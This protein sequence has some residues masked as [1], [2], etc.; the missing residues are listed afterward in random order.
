M[1]VSNHATRTTSA[2][3]A[4]LNRLGLAAPPP[5]V[6]RLTELNALEEAVV[7]SVLLVVSGNVGSGK[8]RLVTEL[9]TRESIQALKPVFVSCR[10]ADRGDAIRARAERELGIL[11]GTLDAALRRQPRLL[12][13]DDAHHLSDSPD[14]LRGLA[15]EAGAGRVLLIASER[16]P[17]RRAQSQRFEMVLEGLDEGS[18]RELWG[19]LEERFGEVLPEACDQALIITGGLPMAL[20][21]EFARARAAAGSSA[22]SLGSAGTGALT[23]TARAVAEAI[24]V[25]DMPITPAGIASLVESAAI[26]DALIELVEGQ[27]I[28]SLADG[29]FVMHAEV[30]RALIEQL[31][32]RRQALEAAAAQKLSSD[33]D[34]GSLFGLL[35]RVDR[36]RECARHWLAAG[37]AERAVE[38]LEAGF[39]EAAARGSAGE[40][41]ALARTIEVASP[42]LAERLRRVRARAARRQGHVASALELGGVGDP[43]TDA[44]LRFQAGEVDSARQQLADLASL[45]GVPS[46]EGGHQASSEGGR[47]AALATA[48]LVRIEI[49]AGE[50]EM[51]RGRLASV[52]NGGISSL[53][54]STRAH[55]HLA[56]ATVA[57][58][59]GDSTSAR[60]SLARARGVGN[61]N[62]ELIAVVDVHRVELLVE[63]GR[64]QEAEQLLDRVG[65]LVAQLDMGVLFDQ[66]RRAR[67]RLAERRGDLIRATD[68]LRSLIARHRECGAEVPAL[69]SE[70]ALAEVM[71]ARGELRDATELAGAARAAASALGLGAMVARTQLLKATIDLMV[72]RTDSAD[73]GLASCLVAEQASVRRGAAQ[74]KRL[75]AAW[76]GTDLPPSPDSETDSVAARGRAIEIAVAQR[77]MVGAL[78][79]AR[80]QAAAAESAGRDAAM[81]TA[82]AVLSR[83]QLARGDRAGATAA[84]SRAARTALRCGMTAA[85]ANALLVLAALARDNNEL[86]SAQAYAQDALNLASTAG[87]P[88]ERLAASRAMEVIAVGDSGGVGQVPERESA[89]AAAMSD[90]AVESTA[91]LLTDL[92]LTAAR[93]FRVISA[94]GQESFVADASPS[95]L[96]M[97]ERG[98]VIDAVREVIVRAGSEVADLRRRSLLKRL[99]FLFAS[100]PNKV[101]SKEEIVQ[102]VWEV[103]Y[104][105]LR[106]DA[107]LFTNIMRIRRL[108]GK[109]GAD[110]IRVSDEGYRFCPDKDFLYVENVE[111]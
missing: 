12:V 40:I 106:H 4:G 44:W 6:G 8:T 65:H 37:V 42:E 58:A 13:I 46:S 52:F 61:L 96:R 101:F 25:I 36:L 39:D 62:V 98:L 31:G 30:S 55:L 89:A 95:V 57:A 70:L 9:C 24:A 19:H 72:L 86:I 41:T 5:F 71:I 60:A 26:E 92:G 38:L 91:Q 104:H 110:L 50:H 80:E 20:R 68:E 18:A 16:L 32:D 78:Q 28:D 99:L 51:A 14:T 90:K 81:V 73:D 49:D 2:S 94:Q 7:D 69:R 82:L 83:L 100:N 108:L 1:G 59:D 107:A 34:G 23:E 56:M 74:K 33:S 15:T 27:L 84:A 22:D 21:R 17:L 87:L 64:T 67:A 77:D 111:T 43:V 11:P 109:E 53:P 45:A 79:L 29:R 66:V 3:R 76:N 103:D 63:E 54:D 10:P 88:L 102:T 85:R 75:L 48:R 105:P 47:Q 93:P 35:D 97:E